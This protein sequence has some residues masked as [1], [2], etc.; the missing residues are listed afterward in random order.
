MPR[1]SVPP[2]GG[3]SR[4]PARPP[5]EAP[6]IAQARRQAAMSGRACYAPLAGCPRSQ[7]PIVLGRGFVLQRDDIAAAEILFR[8]RV[9]PEMITNAL[10][11]GNTLRG[12]DHRLP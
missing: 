2:A 1:T 8:R 3:R 7:R 11:A 12:D 9:D 10:H 4:D 6:R 5:R